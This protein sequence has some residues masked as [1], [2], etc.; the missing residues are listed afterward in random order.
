MLISESAHFS[1]PEFS[2]FGSGS[3]EEEKS[4]EEDEEENA[5]AEEYDEEDEERGFVPKRTVTTETAEERERRI[6]EMMEDP[7]A[8]ASTEPDS[9]FFFHFDEPIEDGAETRLAPEDRSFWRTE[10]MCVC[11][12][13]LLSF[14]DAFALG[15]R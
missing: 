13:L 5:S 15:R 9:R 3:D 6:L 2:L 4:D 1:S 10:P 7:N 11:A 14:A 8:V 12:R